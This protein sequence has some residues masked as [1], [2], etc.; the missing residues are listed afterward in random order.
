[1]YSLKEF[2][3]S[4]TVEERTSCVCEPKVGFGVGGLT[5]TVKGTLWNSFLPVMDITKDLQISTT[6]RMRVGNFLT[7]GL[8]T[9]SGFI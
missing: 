3:L 7:S 5:S 6:S 9:S 2:A 1:M 4:S 8:V